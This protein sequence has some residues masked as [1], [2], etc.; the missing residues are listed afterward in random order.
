MNLRNRLLVVTAIA[1]CLLGCS[2]QSATE[3]QLAKHDLI[4]SALVGYIGE[5]Q[6]QEVLPTA[7]E[8]TETEVKK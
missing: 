4:I 1:F 6:R 5:L 7:Q 8:L 2:T 3:E